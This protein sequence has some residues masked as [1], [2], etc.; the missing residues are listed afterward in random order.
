[1]FTS[2]RQEGWGAVLSESMS[3]ACAVVANSEIGSVPFLIK[4]GING[5]IYSKGSVDSLVECL[6]PLIE[7][8][9]YRKQLGLEAYRTI[10]E[11]WTPRRAAENLLALIESIEK[12]TDNPI[13]DGPCSISRYDYEQ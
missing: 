11:N 8:E 3:C 12:R 4:D 9:A 1:M 13:L 5:R 6:I 10:S 7:S 2:N